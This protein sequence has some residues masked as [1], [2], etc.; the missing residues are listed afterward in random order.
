MTNILKNI[1][2]KK[3]IIGSL[4]QYNFLLLQLVTAGLGASSG[5]CGGKIIL[6]YLRKLSDPLFF[7]YAS[8][9]AV[10][11]KEAVD[12]IKPSVFTR[13]CGKLVFNLEK[14]RTKNDDMFTK[15]VIKYKFSQMKSSRFSP[16]RGLCLSLTPI[17]LAFD[18]SSVKCH[19]LSFVYACAVYA[20]ITEKEN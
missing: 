16:A 10:V 15:E 12:L 17:F 13:N 2:E 9:A 19:P 14:V 5:C 7:V 1:N 6:L 20:S 4:K 8:F 18:N 11:W 3:K